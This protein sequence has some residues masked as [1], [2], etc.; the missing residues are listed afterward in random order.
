MMLNAPS[1]LWRPLAA[2]FNQHVAA[3]K[4]GDAPQLARGRVQ[5]AGSSEEVANIAKGLAMERGGDAKELEK[6]SFRI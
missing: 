3:L 6:R 4:G 5:H 2:W 1:K